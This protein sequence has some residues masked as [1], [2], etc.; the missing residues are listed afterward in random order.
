MTEVIYMQATNKRTGQEYL[1]KVTRRA[2]QT[3]SNLYEFTYLGK[4]YFAR[5][6]PNGKLYCSFYAQ[7]F[8]YIPAKNV[9]E[10]AA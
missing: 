6:A 9:Y 7:Q 8:A 10:I 1:K 2:I 4:R 3:G 5:R